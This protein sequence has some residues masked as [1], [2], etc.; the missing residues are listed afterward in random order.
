[1]IMPRRFAEKVDLVSP[2]TNPSD[3][4][5]IFQF[6]ASK[7]LPAKFGGDLEALPALGVPT[8]S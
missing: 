1:M 7:H 8:D 2:A 4:K 5:K 6:V 3:A